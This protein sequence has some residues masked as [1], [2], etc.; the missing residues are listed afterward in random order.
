MDVVGYHKEKSSSVLVGSR[1]LTQFDNWTFSFLDN[2]K[3]ILLGEIG[4]GEVDFRS[5][6]L[7][8]E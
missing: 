8:M 1:E 6:W 5:R 3:V 2:T 7:T 4:D